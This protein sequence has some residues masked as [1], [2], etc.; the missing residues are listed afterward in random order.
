[1]IANQTLKWTCPLEFNDPFDHRF[2]YLDMTQIKGHS[3]RF[4]ER[5]AEVM[6]EN[7]DVEFDTSSRVG[8]FLDSVRKRSTLKKHRFLP[9]VPK[10]VGEMV[11]SG[12]QAHATLME[13]MQRMLLN[14]RVICVTEEYDSILMWSHYCQA[15]TGVVFEL[16]VNESLALADARKVN[17]STR[18][19]RF[20]TEEELIDYALSLKHVDYGKR[21]EELICTK[22]IDWSYEK[23]WRVSVGKD[24]FQEGDAHYQ[25]ETP[26]TFMRIYV[27]CR[28]LPEDRA[29][30]IRLAKDHLPHMEIWQ[31]CQSENEYRLEFSRLE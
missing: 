24:G 26:E 29:K 3:K 16:A 11:A 22:S 4:L 30:L 9:H 23:E 17:Y 27:A 10:L 21:Y 12:R 8:Q 31:A 20:W 13:S 25:R 7:T 5:F 19:P 18:Y 28:M 2:S 1:M 14:T 6:W 15:H